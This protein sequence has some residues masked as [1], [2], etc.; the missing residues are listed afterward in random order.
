MKDEKQHPEKD[1]NLDIPAEANRTKHINFLE[2]EEDSST[3]TGANA[4]GFAAD[5][6]KEW[7]EGL[8]EGERLR[9][10]NEE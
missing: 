8:E 7:K 1:P 6:Q 10:Q 2:V 3:R 4:D 9:Q 5:R